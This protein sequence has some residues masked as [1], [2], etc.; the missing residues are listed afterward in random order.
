MIFYARCQ[1][2]KETKDQFADEQGTENPVCSLAVGQYFAAM[3][4]NLLKVAPH[5]TT[6]AMFWAECISIFGT[7]S[8]KAAKTTVS[9]SVVKNFSDKA[10]HPIKSAN[11]ICRKKKKEKIKVQTETREW[12]KKETENLKAA[13]M[14]LDPK[15]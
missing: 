12:Q 11:Q 6:F 10:D 4:H 2:P 8:K 5:D 15:K 7:R 9:T 13:S 14:Q 3:A 1:K